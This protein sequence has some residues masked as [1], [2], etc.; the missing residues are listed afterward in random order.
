MAIED[1]ETIQMTRPYDINHACVYFSYRPLIGILH[2][3]IY[4]YQQT[5]FGHNWLGGWPLPF[6]DSPSYIRIIRYPE[7]VT[8]TLNKQG[9][10]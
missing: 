7:E 10:R 8:G 2:G 3:T 4:A 1:E 6:Q 5:T 9:S